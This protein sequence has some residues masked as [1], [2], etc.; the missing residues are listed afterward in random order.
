MPAFSFL[1][2]VLMIMYIAV[3]FY[4][5]SLAIVKKVEESNNKNMHN[6]N[7]EKRTDSS[8]NTEKSE[9]EYSYENVPLWVN[10]VTFFTYTGSIVMFLAGFIIR[11]TG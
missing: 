3:G 2:G 4:G 6:Y 11:L 1:A 7:C 9:K 5:S 8:K 10:L